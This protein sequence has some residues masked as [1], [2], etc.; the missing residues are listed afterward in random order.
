MYQNRVHMAISAKWKSTRK[1]EQNPPSLQIKESFTNHK[2]D[3]LKLIYRII[4]QV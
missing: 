2:A 3:H 4:S 1:K